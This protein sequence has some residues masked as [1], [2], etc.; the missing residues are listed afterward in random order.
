MAEPTTYPGQDL[1]LPRSGRGSLAGWNSRILALVV[2]WLASMAVAVGLF[3][4]AVMTGGG[5]RAWMVLATFCVE[6]SMLGA[7]A[8]GSFGQILFRIAVVRLDGQPLGFPRAI[9]RAIL[10]SLALPALIIGANRRGLQDLAL[11]TV[12]TNRR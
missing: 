8:A 9:A 7:V 3:G 4:S 11:G 5:W 1:G 10:V 6:S 2:D 12:V